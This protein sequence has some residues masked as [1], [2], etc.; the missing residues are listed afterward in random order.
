[1]MTVVIGVVDV[2]GKEWEAED[3][4]PHHHHHHRHQWSRRTTVDPSPKQNAAA[5]VRGD[6]SCKS[7][8]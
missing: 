2:I 6:A 3:C 1:M 7:T 8:V 4:H 5:I